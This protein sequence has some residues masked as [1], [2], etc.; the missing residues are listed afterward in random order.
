MLANGEFVIPADVVSK[1]GNGSNE[2][3]ASVLDQFL[4]VVRKDANSNGE[5][6]PP[7]SK[8]PLAYLLD[9][10]RTMKA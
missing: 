5:E 4:K 8:G 10:K 6:L 1:L 9:A 3:G 2:A 7:K